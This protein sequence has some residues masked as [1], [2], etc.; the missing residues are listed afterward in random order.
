GETS[1]DKELLSVLEAR[2]Q[3]WQL[4]KMLAEKR[5]S[6]LITVT[7]CIPVAFRT[8]EDFELI[9]QR[10]CR[11]FCDILESRGQSFSIEGHL[12]GSDGPAFF[13]STKAEAGMIKKICVEA[14]ETIAGGRM[15]DIDVM[16]SRGTPVSRTDIG[17]PQRKCFICDKPAVSCV[18]RRLHSQEEVNAQVERL[19][20]QAEEAFF[21]N[22][23]GGRCESR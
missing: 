3:R 15:L 1:M 12:R 18:S 10:L 5:H 9:F 17:L 6:C 23:D 16:D 11:S 19:K 8:G 13:I 22:L 21:V 14:E 20:R 2:E 7:L 4:R